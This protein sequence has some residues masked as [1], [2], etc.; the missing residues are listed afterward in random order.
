MS[1]RR[2]RLWDIVFVLVLLAAIPLIIDNL[3]AGR[4]SL[5]VLT[6]L[7]LGAGLGVAYYSVRHGDSIGP[8]WPGRLHSDTTTSDVNA[9]V[10]NGIQRDETGRLHSWLLHGVVS[11]FVATVILSIGLLIAYE[12]ALLV[13]SQATG[14]STLERWF[15][16]LTHNPVTS[17][18]QLN[19][20]VALLLNFAAGIGWAI[21][22][23]GWIEPRLAGPAWRRGV[24][25]SL[26]PWVLSLIVFLPLVDGG[27]L[28][29]SLHAGPLPV[30][31]NL[32]AHLLYGA[33]LGAVFAGEQLVR[34]TGEPE[35]AEDVDLVVKAERMM[36]TGILPGFVLGGVIGLAGTYLVSLSY[37][38]WLVAVFSAIAGS[39]IGMLI[40]SFAGLSESVAAER[41]SKPSDDT[42]G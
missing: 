39:V 14:A 18:A 42:P 8:R 33:T 1:I 20:P 26:V 32:L 31:G 10:T 16:S 15:W 34:M 24:M 28:G 25:F 17:S 30:I 38:R 40:G 9:P 6:L 36:A 7:F 27:F 19:L 13:A 23:A 12:I 2:L 29:I 5:V 35:D 41:S 21:I 11:G 37:D 22:Y 3:S 4:Y